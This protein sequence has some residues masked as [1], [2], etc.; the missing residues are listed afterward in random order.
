LYFA[1]LLLIAFFQV[2]NQLTNL[3]S[4]GTSSAVI[5]TP[6]EQIGFQATEEYAS[7]ISS[8]RPQSGNFAAAHSNASHTHA[9]SPLRKESFPAE[10]MG[11]AEF[12]GSL[13]R[14]LQAPSDHAL[15]SEVED[16]DTIHVDGPGRRH[17]RVY[18]GSGESTDSLGFVGEVEELHEEHGYSAPIL[19]SDEVA[20]EPFG[21]QLQPAV[22]PLNERRSGVLDDGTYYQRSESASSLAG[23]RPSS[24]PG[25]IHGTLPGFT[26]SSSTPLEDLDEYEPLFPEDGHTSGTKKPLTPADKLKR[27][28]AKVRD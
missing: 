6:S 10:S 26:V 17:N 8:P 20:K 9:D 1:L 2:S 3:K 14:G 11:K 5:G 15:E 19:A 21:F 27:P 23:S 13:A 22:S 12:E 18:G 24:R 28:E 16:E 7:R 4:A 25:S